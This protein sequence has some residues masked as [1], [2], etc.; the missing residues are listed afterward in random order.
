MSGKK[1]PQCGLVN[2]AADLECRRCGAFLSR[3]GQAL[4]EE[5]EEGK[6]GRRSLKKKLLWIIGATFSVLFLCYVS[7]LA[8][9]ER[10]NSEQ[11]QVVYRAT[12]LLE[13]NGF[14]GDVFMLR[15]FASFRSTDNWWNKY[16]GH[17]EAYAATNFPF[18]IVT[19]YPEFFAVSVDDNERAVM[20]LHESYHLFGYGEAATLEGVWRNKSRLGWTAEKYSQTKVWKNTIELTRGNVPQLFQCG[21]DGQ[22]DCAP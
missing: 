8:S 9:S 10:L 18:E 22:S 11:K 13:Q 6:G 20:L 21:P 14:K 19:L 12:A 2:F 16:L 17:R 7:L 1:C 15:H 3:Q 4:G 5:T